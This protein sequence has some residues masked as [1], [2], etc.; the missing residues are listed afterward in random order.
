MGW[1]HLT[2]L[3]WLHAATYFTFLAS[4]NLK[5]LIVDISAPGYQFD[6]GFMC[7]VHDIT[8]MRG[9]FCSTEGKHDSRTLCWYV[10]GTL[11]AF[12]FVYRSS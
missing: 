4:N 10:L 1:P 2:N 11:Y 5:E 12:L 8:D 6:D 3:Q 9:K 7:K